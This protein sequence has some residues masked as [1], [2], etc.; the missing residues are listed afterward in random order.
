MHRLFSSLYETRTYEQLRSQSRIDRK[1]LAASS[2]DEAGARYAR[3]DDG[4]D[5]ALLRNAVRANDAPGPRPNLMCRWSDHA[6]LQ[7][8]RRASVLSQA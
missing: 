7:L 8:N 3:F 1:G 6:R 2:L 4:V 5:A